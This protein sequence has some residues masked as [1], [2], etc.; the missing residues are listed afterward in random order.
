MNLYLCKYL[1]NKTNKNNILSHKMIL[2]LQFILIIHYV[3]QPL[4]NLLVC[5]QNKITF[6]SCGLLIKV[7]NLIKY[8]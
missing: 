1:D 2:P 3:T 4:D 8:N 5:T 7:L 6:N